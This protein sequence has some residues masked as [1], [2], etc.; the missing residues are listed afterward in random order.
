MF[1]QKTVLN[2]EHDSPVVVSRSTYRGTERLDIRR[3]YYTQSGE[4]KPTRKGVS[5]TLEDG[6][7]AQAV[8]EL[9]KLLEAGA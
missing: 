9:V 8:A 3:Y 6:L 2:P 1:E 4:L 5:L 7:A